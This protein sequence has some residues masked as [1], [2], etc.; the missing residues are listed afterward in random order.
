MVKLQPY[1][2]FGI[3]MVHAT[4]GVV[5]FQPGAEDPKDPTA[6]DGVFRTVKMF[7]N[8]YNRFAL[9][10]RMVAGAVVLGLEGSVA[11][12]TNPVQS[13]KL[14]GNVAPPTQFTRQFG[15]SLRLGVGF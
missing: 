15:A 9:G 12:G 11:F 13:D 5:D 3:S 10:L 7:D 1:F 6:D 4:T 2:Q 8:L 14:T